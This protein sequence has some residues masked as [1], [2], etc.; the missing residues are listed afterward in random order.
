MPKVFRVGK[1]KYVETALEG[2]GAK[3]HGGRWNSKGTPV[4]YASDSIALAALEL[5]VHLKRPET[6]VRYVIMQLE[7]ADDQVLGLER[8]DL[9]PDWRNNP[10]PPSTAEIGDEWFDNGASLAL[11]V[12]S[13]VVP[14]QYNFLLNPEH[15]D[16]Q[17]VADQAVLFPFGLDQRL[18]GKRD[19]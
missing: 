10:P 1:Q 9:P 19:G 16:F 13:V 7:F 5:L 12:P 15:P 3:R 4:V 17:A 6:L 14:E 11:A 2:L 8:D 18:S